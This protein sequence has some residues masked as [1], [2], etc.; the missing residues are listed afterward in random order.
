MSHPHIYMKNKNIIFEELKEISPLMVQISKSNVYSVSSSYF[1]EFFVNIIKKIR[2]IEELYNQ[3]APAAPYY[4][5]ANYFTNL[6]Q[7]IV[8][9]ISS[10]QKLSDEVFEEIQAIAPVLNT[11]SKKPVYT[12]PA[13]FFEKVQM[14][15]MEVEKQE[16]KVVSI[17][18]WPKVFKFSAAAVIILFSGIGLYTITTKNNIS[19][20]FGSNARNKVKNLSKEEIVNF[21]KFNIPAENVTTVSRYKLKND[22]AIKSSL[23]RISDKEIEQFLK[24]TGESDGI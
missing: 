5:P 9:K 20:A 22:N 15:V 16:A 13:D 18:K 12:V 4:I 19:L 11:I 10:G 14:P 2:L 7:V 6:P 1:N 23:K 21:L 17:S 8:D 24:E 3:A